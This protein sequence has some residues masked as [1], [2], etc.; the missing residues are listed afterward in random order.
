MT[1]GTRKAILFKGAAE[2]SFAFDL[3]PTPLIICDA[4]LD[5]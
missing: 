2:S 5:L 1:L 4:K 3:K